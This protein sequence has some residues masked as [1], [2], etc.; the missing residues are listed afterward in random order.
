MGRLTGK[1]VVISG[2]ASGIGALAWRKFCEEGASVV[3]VDINE[4]AGKRLADELRADGH[5][6]EFFT[7]DVTCIEAIECLAASIR[8]RFGGLDVLYNNAGINLARPLLETTE[9]EWDTVHNVDLKSA[10]LMMKA[11]A[12]LMQDGPGS[13]INTAS[14][15]GLVAYDNMAAYCAA[16]G[17]LIMLTKAAALELAPSIRVNVICPTLIDTPM[18]RRF[19]GDLPV[20]FDQVWK[21]FEDGH[22]LGR[23]GKPEDVVPLAV[24]LASDESLMM[25]GV[26]LPVDGGWSIR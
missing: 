13:I 14:M 4:S 11:F 26:A 7:T 6:G 12:P 10:F 19:V 5:D 9:A 22:P 2:V 16:K 25:T 17:G 23:I 3:G 20:D 18:S 21:A 24:Y 1:T 8:D 15:G